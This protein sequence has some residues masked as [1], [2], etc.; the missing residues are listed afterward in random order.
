MVSVTFRYGRDRP[1]APGVSTDDV[2]LVDGGF[3][4]CA[5][6]EVFGR[7]SRCWWCDSPELQWTSAPDR[8]GLP[9]RI[10]ARSMLSSWR[11]PNDLQLWL[12]RDDRDAELWMAR[13][14]T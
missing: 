13:T 9:T 8:R 3:Y 5:A 10:H 12:G 14:A 2:E 6:C 4:Y 11:A 1:P 7:G